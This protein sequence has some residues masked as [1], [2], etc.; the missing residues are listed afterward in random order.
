MDGNQVGPLGDAGKIP[1]ISDCDPGD[2]GAMIALFEGAGDARPGS[3]L[4]VGAIRAEGYGAVDI[5]GGGETRLDG[6]FLC[7]KRVLRVHPGVE[8]CDELAVAVTASEPRAVGADQGNAVDEQGWNWLILQH[9]GNL[10][11]LQ[12]FI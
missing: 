4:F 7:Q 10:R 2:V 3:G 6:Q 9:P 5:R 12:Q 1:P 8:Q 11:L